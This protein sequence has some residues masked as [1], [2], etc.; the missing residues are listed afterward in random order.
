MTLIDQSDKIV[1]KAIKLGAKQAEVSVFTADEALTRF[2][3][4]MIHQNVFSKN[5]YT[6]VKVIL[7]NNLIGS[8]AI[9]SIE[10]VQAVTAV[11]RAIKIAKISKPD[12]DFRTLPEP[13]KIVTM[14]EIFCENTANNTP[15]ERVEGVKTIID[16]ALDYNSSVKWSAGAYMTDTIHCAISNSLGVKA[17]AEYTQA[18]VDTIVRANDG[19][20]DGSGYSAKRSHDVK[21]FDFAEIG[22]SA[23]N[24]AVTSMNPKQIPLGDYEAILRP[25]VMSTFC[26]FIGTLGFSAKTYHEGRS[27]IKDKLGDQL[28]SDSLSIVDN[29]RDVNTLN[30]LPFDGEGLPKRSLT[31]VNNGVAE[32]LCYD[33]YTAFKEGKENTAHSLLKFTR[34]WSLEGVPLPTNQVIKPSDAELVE[35]VEETKKGVLIT[36]LWYT[37]PIREDLGVISGMTSDGIWYIENGEIKFPS[38]Q[39]RYTDS[40]LRILNSVDLVGSNKTVEVLPGFTVPTLKVG[41][42]RFTG[43]TQF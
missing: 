43:H 28:F 35:M 7:A 19:G 16:S 22:K 30:A 12:P 18:S 24:D 32:N 40:L 17:E 10:N 27:F 9:N 25:E 39:M 4:N 23:A 14:R 42:F 5:Y 29:G 20:I 2:T 41:K 11:E 38:Q 1:E 3:K 36:R 15:E 8:S 37:N 31:L 6:N 34:G 26:M 33:S 13:K 21:D